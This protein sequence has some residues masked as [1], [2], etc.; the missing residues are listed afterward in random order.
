MCVEYVLVIHYV[1]IIRCRCLDNL[2]AAFLVEHCLFSRLFVDML[3]VAVIEEVKM[4]S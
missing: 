1:V 4:L 3:S 2:E